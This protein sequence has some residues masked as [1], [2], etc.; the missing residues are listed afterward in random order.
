MEPKI[1]DGDRIV[2]IVVSELKALGYPIEL[3][4]FVDDAGNL[5]AAL[6]LTG[7]TWSEKST[8]ERQKSREKSDPPDAGSPRDAGSPAPASILADKTS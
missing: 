7:K 4:N 6:V 8:L 3:V 1:A 2:I 5:T